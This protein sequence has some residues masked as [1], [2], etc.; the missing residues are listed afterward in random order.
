MSLK[1]SDPPTST[2]QT[3]STPPVSAPSSTSV[4]DNEKRKSV[5]RKASTDS[6]STMPDVEEILTAAGQEERPLSRASVLSIG[7][8]SSQSSKSNIGK[9]H[10]LTPY[11]SGS[12]FNYLFFKNLI[13]MTDS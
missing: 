5:I 7:S 8:E 12:F 2:K 10:Y 9:N 11:V 6:C 1:A 13:C 4:A 3:S